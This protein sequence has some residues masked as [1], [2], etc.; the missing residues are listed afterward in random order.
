[1]QDKFVAIKYGILEIICKFN[2][3]E[4]TSIGTKLAE[5]TVS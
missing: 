4:I 5:H 1:M 3:I 2:S